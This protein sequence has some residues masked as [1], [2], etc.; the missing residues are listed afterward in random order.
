MALTLLLI[1]LAALAFGVRQVPVA[2]VAARMLQ[3]EEYERM[4]FLRWGMTRAWIAHRGV[5]SAFAASAVAFVIGAATDAG[6]GLIAAGWLVASV[7]GALLWQWTPPKRALVITARMRRIL[8]VAALLLA[9]VCAGVALLLAAGEWIVAGVL[10]VVPLAA[11]TLFAQTVLVA[12]DIVL[13]PVESLVRQ[14]YL[15]AAR[16]RLAQVHPQVVAV[17][18]SYGKTSTKHILSHL[19]EGQIDALPTRKSFNT[20]MGVTRVINEDLETGHRLFIVEMDAYGP[21]EIRAMCDLVHPHVSVVTS[22]GPQH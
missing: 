4:R 9:L 18:G 13:M 7:M 22:V 3:I 11:A 21:G 14:R 8:A 2:F 15:R 16:A 6:S 5:V 19:V 1:A 20:L 10:C 17:A 12:S